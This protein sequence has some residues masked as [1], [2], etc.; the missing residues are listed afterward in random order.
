MEFGDIDLTDGYSGDDNSL[1]DFGT[2]KTYDTNGYEE[3]GFLDMVSLPATEESVLDGFRGKQ[4]LLEQ[5]VKQLTA[6]AQKQQEDSEKLQKRSEKLQKD[7]RKLQRQTKKHHTRCR[8]NNKT[9]EEL[10]NRVKRCKES[11]SA[12]GKLHDELQK[13]RR[14]AE[15]AEAWDRKKKKKK[16][17]KKG[18]TRREDEICKQLLQEDEDDCKQPGRAWHMTDADLKNVKALFHSIDRNPL[19]KKAEDCDAD[20][21]LWKCLATNERISLAVR[22]MCAGPVEAFARFVTNKRK[23]SIKDDN[24]VKKLTTKETQ[25]ISKQERTMITEILSEVDRILHTFVAT[26]YSKLPLEM[27]QVVPFVGY[28]KVQPTSLLSYMKGSFKTHGR[29]SSIKECAKYLASRLL[30]PTRTTNGKGASLE[31]G[32]MPTKTIQKLMDNTESQT[33]MVTVVLNSDGPVPVEPS[34]LQQQLFLKSEQT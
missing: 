19:R 32:Y 6:D 31:G 11:A 34:M 22:E 29:R 26:D 1:S 15:R 16:K 14:Q 24:N 4:G 10:N 8:D 7:S 9:R 33:Q 23:K 5:E 20:Y 27:Q 3:T 28:Y 30:L 13:L 17:K 12:L 2:P 25:I 18:D 21:R